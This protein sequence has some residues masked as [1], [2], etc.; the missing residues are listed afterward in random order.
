MGYQGGSPI[1]SHRRPVDSHVVKGA[2]P[3]Q[4]L[5]RQEELLTEDVYN[6]NRPDETGGNHG[7]R[8]EVP[9][10]VLEENEFEPSQS[11][12]FTSESDRSS[13]GSEGFFYG[14]PAN[15]PSLYDLVGEFS[16]HQAH[17]APQP[18]TKTKR[19]LAIPSEPLSR[20]GDWRNFS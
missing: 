9:Q 13:Q 15:F 19:H 5:T 3:P 17:T 7:K 2:I 8:Q 4:E 18:I 10:F 12:G 11:S 16:H 14:R 1:P 20:G 6:M